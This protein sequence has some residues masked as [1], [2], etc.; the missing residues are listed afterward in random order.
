M[1]AHRPLRTAISHLVI[2]GSVAIPRIS[3]AQ[4]DWPSLV[5]T[6]TSLSDDDMRYFGDQPPSSR[7]SD[8][9]RGGAEPIPGTL[10]RVSV[11]G[12]RLD[13]KRIAG[14]A[15]LIDEEFL[16]RWEH[17][18]VQRAIRSVPGV[19]VRDEDG[20]GLRPNIGMRG[21]FSDRSSKIT[22]MEDG[23]LLKPAPYAAPA[24]YYF[25]LMTRIRELEVFKG[26]AAVVA[27]PNTIGGAI[28]LKT[29]EVPIGT[30]GEL[31]IAGGN[32]S[33][34][35]LHGVAGTGTETWGV[36][37]EGVHLTSAGFKDLP[38]NANTGFA[39]NDLMFKARLNTKASAELQHRLDLKLGWGSEVSDETYLGLTDADFAADPYQRYAASELD[40]MDWDRGQIELAYTTGQEQWSLRIQGYYHPFARVWNRLDG[41]NNPARPTLNEV[42]RS[43]DPASLALQEVLRGEADSVVVGDAT[44]DTT[45]NARTYGSQGVQ[46]GFDADVSTGPVAHLIEAGARFHHDWIEREHTLEEYEVFRGRMIPVAGTNSVPGGNPRL[47]T[48]N[49]DS[50]FAGAFYLKDTISWQRLTVS[51]G[52]RAEL[53]ST[54]REDRIAGTD[55]QQ[56]DAIALPGVGALYEIIPGFSALAGVH[57]GFSPVAP[58]QDEEVNPETS[59]N[60]EA[61][62]RFDREGLLLETIGFFND[63]ENIVANCTFSTGCPSDAGEQ[64]SLGSASVYGVEANARLS[65]PGPFG[66]RYELSANY[67]YT[68]AEFDTEITGSL[69]ARFDG[70]L[71]GDTIPDIPE[72]MGAFYATVSSGDRWAVSIGGFGQSRMIDEAEKGRE[73]GDEFFTDAFFVFDATAHYRPTSWLELYAG[74]QNLFDADYI[75][76]RRPFGA[77]PGR[78]L[79]AY[80]G[81]KLTYDGL[82]LFS[83]GPSRSASRLAAGG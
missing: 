59:W 48:D 61:G 62:L 68:R 39:R 31:D 35:K 73:L 24:A 46:L 51:P 83:G 16:E 38:S 44:L 60:W 20:F 74:G 82:P 26:P 34:L 2:V 66:F 67:T 12:S 9:N 69:N 63:Y 79:F 57:R 37:F 41:F 27:G 6:S 11:F 71:P 29:R 56:F 47:R 58:G 4:A 49:Y 22:L 52:V 64:D 25:P 36:L 8:P 15:H 30:I 65:A 17:D 5:P 18:D 53:I 76:S 32:T 70:A 75:A 40:R 78:P 7:E 81:L 1:T 10:D 50:A 45:R 23:V 80:V 14:S 21:A 28:N 77:R 3:S 13:T 42:L 19:Y 33:Y 54:R 43:S 55:Q 72:H